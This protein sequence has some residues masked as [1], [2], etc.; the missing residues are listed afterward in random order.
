[1]LLCPC[2]F[3]CPVVEVWPSAASQTLSSTAMSCS[4]RR[5]GTRLWTERFVWLHFINIKLLQ[6]Y[7]QINPLTEH[8]TRKQTFALFLWKPVFSVPDS[9]VNKRFLL[10]TPTKTRRSIRLFWNH[11]FLFFLLNT[12]LQA[13]NI[14]V[15]LHHREH[16]NDTN[17]H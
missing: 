8:W 16:T 13:G 9:L 1:M 5:T 12:S 11:N 14:D 4:L 15:F 6:K 2:R 10:L 3:W 7:A 17:T